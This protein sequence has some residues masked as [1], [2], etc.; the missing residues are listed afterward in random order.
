M[1]MT[2]VRNPGALVNGLDLRKA[3]ARAVSGVELSGNLATAQ[4][5]AGF[6]QDCIDRLHERVPAAFEP[7]KAVKVKA[8]K[9]TE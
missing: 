4:S 7:A 2:D 8:K 5:L 3:A 1:F 9:E 6:F